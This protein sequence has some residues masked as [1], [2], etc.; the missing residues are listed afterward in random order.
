MTFGCDLQVNCD[1]PRGVG[2]LNIPVARTQSMARR[3]RT[4]SR[5]IVPLQDALADKLIVDTQFGRGQIHLKTVFVGE[6]GCGKSQLVRRLLQIQFNPAVKSTVA[7]D[8]RKLPVQVGDTLVTLD[9]W[10][11]A[12]QEMYHNLTSQFFRD[13]MICAIVYDICDRRSFQ[14]C[15]WWIKTISE[16]TSPAPPAVTLVRGRPNM[17]LIGTKCDMDHLRQVRRKDAN[18]LAVRRGLG[19]AEVTAIAGQGA[20]ELE[21]AIHDLAA[22]ALYAVKGNR[23]GRG[24]TAPVAVID[25]HRVFV[26]ED[27]DIETSLIVRDGIGMLVKRTA[28]T[29]NND[30]EPVENACCV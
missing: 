16:D 13:A 29:D 2:R 6:S 7:V 11:T 1:A 30:D 15:E 10:D 18:E 28:E 3:E 17:I 5:V 22:N 20:G 14:K 9:I 24:A 26:P 27:H 4:V 19:F 8:I 23:K 25:H 21:H 12:G